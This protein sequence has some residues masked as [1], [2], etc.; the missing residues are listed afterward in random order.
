MELRSNNELSAVRG[1]SI[2]GPDGPA[3]TYD[4]NR[5]CVYPTCE[6]KLSVYNASPTCWLHEEAKQFILRVRNGVANGTAA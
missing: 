1:F 4:R 3:A 2:G 5:V 6:T